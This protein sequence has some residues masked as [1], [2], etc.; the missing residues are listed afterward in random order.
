MG[1]NWRKLIYFTSL[2]LTRSHQEFQCHLF[3]ISELLSNVDS[4]VADCSFS[5]SSGTEIAQGSARSIS[6]PPPPRPAL[7][8][9]HTKSPSNAVYT[10]LWRIPA[11][12][13][14]Q[15][16]GIWTVIRQA[17]LWLGAI[18]STLA[19]FREE[20]VC[21][22]DLTAA[23]LTLG[24]QT[25]DSQHGDFDE[26][27]NGRKSFTIV[28]RHCHPTS[29]ES[30]QQWPLATHWVMAAVVCGGWPNTTSCTR[31]DACARMCV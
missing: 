12:F 21:S 13:C 14:L 26:T 31:M 20:V 2:S 22:A 25:L 27:I 1:K 28:E 19:M 23:M 8:P 7:P 30:G 5:S 17:G 24:W 6:C 4:I 29:R 9:N 3:T 16:A 18:I 11:I 10:V 15:S